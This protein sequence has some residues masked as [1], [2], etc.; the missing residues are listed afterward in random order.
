MTGRWGKVDSGG[1]DEPCLNG[2]FYYGWVLRSACWAGQ[3]RLRV[4]PN[5]VCSFVQSHSINLHERC[6]S[7]IVK[8][9]IYSNSLLY[10]APVPARLRRPAVPGTSQCDSFGTGSFSPFKCTSFLF[11]FVFLLP[12]SLKLHRLSAAPSFL[13]LSFLSF[14]PR[15]HLEPLLCCVQDPSLRNLFQFLALDL[16]N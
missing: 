1:L 6:A 14:L 16:V 4:Q 5:L 10:G 12:S 8:S 2:L 7:L 15:P 3:C 11:F 13:L 9:S